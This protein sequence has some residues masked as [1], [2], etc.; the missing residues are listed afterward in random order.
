MVKMCIATYARYDPNHRDEDVWLRDILE[1]KGHSVDIK[2]WMGP[3]D[4]RS[5][6]A[7][8]VGSTYNIPSAPDQFFVWLGAC[9][10]DGRK[11]LI[12]DRAVLELGIR[13]DLYWNVLRNSGDRVL[14]ESLVPT[15]FKLFTEGG[16]ANLVEE[17]EGLW[18]S[19]RLVFKPIISADSLHTFVFDP[20]GTALAH[21]PDRI[22]RDRSSLPRM[23]D[24]IW[25]DHRLRGIMAQP[26]LEGV[27]TGELSATFVGDQ[28]VGA[29]KKSPGF[30]P[31]PAATREF[32]TNRDTLDALRD[33][34]SRVM[35][36][37][38]RYAVAPVRTR[39]D[40]IPQQ[41][42]LRLLEAEFVEPNCNFSTFEE[43]ARVEALDVLA[44][45]IINAAQELH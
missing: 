8:F 29:I 23:L 17:C 10:T 24:A 7:I 15:K 35:A 32:V 38:A 6:E 19:D 16:Y 40:V 5:Y 34:G 9:E 3:A 37:I 1:E 36:A 45:G 20:N 33:L 14:S 25:S 31:L 2:D 21:D 13:K 42:G 27:E 22:V 12:N 28:L 39:L 11:R 18:P 43:S 44:N 30:G 26:Y 4:W 41:G